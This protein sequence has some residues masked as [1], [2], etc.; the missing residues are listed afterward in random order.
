MDTRKASLSKQTKGRWRLFRWPPK[1]FA[2]QTMRYEMGGANWLRSSLSTNENANVVD[3]PARGRHIYIG[4]EDATLQLVQL[5]DAG[6]EGI[7]NQI[8]AVDGIPA[9]SGERSAGV[10]G[11]AAPGCRQT[12]GRWFTEKADS[13]LSIALGRAGEGHP[14]GPLGC[15]PSPSEV[16]RSCER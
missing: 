13:L 4:T 14:M 2:G 10:E 12:G 5:V 16:G 15:Q 6:R 1:A 7:E 9:Q 3:G 8:E 11:G